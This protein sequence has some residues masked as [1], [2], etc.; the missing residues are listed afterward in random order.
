MSLLLPEPDKL[1][2]LQARWL[3]SFLNQSKPVIPFKNCV[4]PFPNHMIYS[5]Q[6]QMF[7]PFPKLDEMT[8]Q[9]KVLT[10]FVS[11]RVTTV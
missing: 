7:Q 6:S 1:T 4:N 2:Q 3:S 11:K 8:P 10:P 5:F 9:T